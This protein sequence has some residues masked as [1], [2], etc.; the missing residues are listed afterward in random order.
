MGQQQVLILTL[1][2]VI[3][4]IAVY[5]GIDL[6]G[7]TS[8]QAHVDL[9]L[10]HAVRISSDAAAWRGKESPFLG[11][12]NSYTSL[13]MER[14]LIDEEMLPG[15]VRITYAQNDSL[16]VTAVSHDYPEVGLSVHVSGVDIVETNIVYDGSIS[17]PGVGDN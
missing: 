13:D 3:V 10:S 15:T 1:T 14:L 11:G 8:R 17:L 9:L 12:G 7:R 2:I 4:S 16:V 5:I 6:F